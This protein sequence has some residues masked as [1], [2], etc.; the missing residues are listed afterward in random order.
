[1]DR[2][3]GWIGVARA[4]D[5]LVVHVAEQL[6]LAERALGIDLV[7]EGVGDLLDGH[8]LRRL[9]VERR[10][11]QWAYHEITNQRGQSEAAPNDA[12]RR[13]GERADQTMP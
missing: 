6:D 1:L 8:L 5:I 4:T 13:R 2:R 10:A 7:V 12:N 3:G 9:G 11:G